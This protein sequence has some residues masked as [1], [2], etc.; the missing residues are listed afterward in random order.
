MQGVQ[1]THG[2][3]V[4]GFQTGGQLNIKDKNSWPCN[5]SSTWGKQAGVRQ[6]SPLSSPAVN[7]GERKF[8][9]ESD[10]RVSAMLV[11]VA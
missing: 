3:E 2:L 10:R 11:F 7:A 5:T 6:T 8:A 4:T 1:S 9:P